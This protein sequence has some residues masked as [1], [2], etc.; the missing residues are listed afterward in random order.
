MKGLE[1][2]FSDPEE[3]RS[4]II[5]NQLYGVDNV[6][7]KTI[8]SQKLLGTKG[9]DHHIMNEDSLKINWKKDMP[10]FDVVVGNSPYQVG[11]HLNFLEL[12]YR[13]SDKWVIFVHPAAWLIDERG[14]NEKFNHLKKL[15]DGEITEL[16]FFNGNPVF[17]V[18]LFVPLTITVIEKNSRKDI[19]I[20]DRIRGNNLQ[21]D[22]LYKINKWNDYKIYPNLSNKIKSLAES[23]NFSKHISKE[24]KKYYVNLTFLRGHKN[25]KETG[26]MVLDDFYS[27]F[28]KDIK[29]S[30][31]APPRDKRWRIYFSFDTNEEAQ[32]FIDFM[33]TRWGMFAFSIFKMDQTISGNFTGAIPWLDWSRSWTEKDFEDLIDATPEEKEFVYKNIPDYYGISK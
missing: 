19:K 22:S 8:I 14:T 27:L 6:K 29:I 23:D 3:R 10:K 17:N 31:T 28:P 18:G 4:H 16:T 26:P 1:T 12:S 20:I 25:D 7:F 21:I 30:K 13:I 33:K 24:D 9:L 32:N 11:V 2:E 5:E 15:L